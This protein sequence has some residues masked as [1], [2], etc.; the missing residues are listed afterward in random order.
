M[1]LLALHHYQS[2]VAESKTKKIDPSSNSQKNDTIGNTP[3]YTCN[4]PAV[5]S[6]LEDLLGD[7]EGL[8][9]KFSKGFFILSGEI[10]NKKD[11]ERIVRVLEAINDG[12]KEKIVFKNLVTLKK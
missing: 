9:I 7:I 1:I 4:T 8:K 5:Y 3:R 12:R 10:Q 11:M 6:Q 2:A